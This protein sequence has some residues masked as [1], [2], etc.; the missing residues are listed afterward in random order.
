MR[1]FRPVCLSLVLSACASTEPFVDTNVKIDL[2][3]TASIDSVQQADAVLKAV[4]LSRA[5]VEWRYQQIERICYTK[6]FVNSCLL[7]AKDQR[8]IDLEKIKKSEVDANYFKR[9]NTV[10]EMDRSL[11]EKNKQNPEPVL[12]VPEIV[13][14]P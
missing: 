11:A 2:P 8:R 5:Q 9:E 1:W 14:T 13:N 3:P 12:V 10:E 4:T 7:D 6:F